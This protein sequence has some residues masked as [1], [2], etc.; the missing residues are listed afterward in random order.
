MLLHTI[1]H[2]SLS[3]NETQKSYFAP[4]RE[5]NS[6]CLCTYW[7]CKYFSSLFIP[8][9]RWCL[10]HCQQGT[11]AIWSANLHSELLTFPGNGIPKLIIFWCVF[12]TCFT[13]YRMILNENWQYVNPDQ[14]KHLI[15]RF[16]PN[17]FMYH[18]AVKH[19]PLP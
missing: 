9:V 6:G 13:N 5:Q 18:Y 11:Y 17:L 4:C 8:L 2:I 16:F 12:R 14:S 1:L 10:S 15:G 7:S 3:E 19:L